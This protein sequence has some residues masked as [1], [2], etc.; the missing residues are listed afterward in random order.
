MNIKNKNKLNKIRMDIHN[1]AYNGVNGD[2]ISSQEESMLYNIVEHLENVINCGDYVN[3]DLCP[4]DT[5]YKK[6]K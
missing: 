6:K 5:C 2:N 3:C 1:M 4:S